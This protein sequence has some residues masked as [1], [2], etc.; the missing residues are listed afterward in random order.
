MMYY[1]AQSQGFTTAEKRI[2]VTGVIQ[3]D[4]EPLA[5]G[6]II[7]TPIDIKGAATVVSR[8]FNTGPVRGQY[9]IP[10]DQ[11]LIPGKYKV[12]VRQEG[13]RWMSNSR[14]PVFVRMQQKRGNM[15]E[16]ERKEWITYARKRDLSPSIDV[17]RSYSKSRPGDK[18][19]MTVD[20]KPGMGTFDVT[21]LSK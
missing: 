12:E 21:V 20:V 19:E 3:L 11:G 8:V 4:G 1:W 14:D 16:E 18:E 5:H 9:R 6:Y 13:T 17:L 10:A 7:F 2:S 15:T